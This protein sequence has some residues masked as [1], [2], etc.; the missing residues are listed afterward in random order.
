MKAA[1][2]DGV[3]VK[4]DRVLG[5]CG[6]VERDDGAHD[7]HAEDL[8]SPICGVE[9]HA[10][11]YAGTRAGWPAGDGSEDAVSRASRLEHAMSGCMHGCGVMLARDCPCVR[12]SSRDT[13]RRAAISRGGGSNGAAQTG[14]WPGTSHSVAPV[15]SSRKSKVEGE[16]TRAWSRT[17]QP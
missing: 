10:C 8:A 14:R 1:A 12:V 15:S 17:R 13:V 11:M 5:L 7:G 6:V 16:V 4:S 9:R 3:D 2:V